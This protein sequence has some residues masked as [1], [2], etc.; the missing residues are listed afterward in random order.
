MAKNILHCFVLVHNSWPPTTFILNS[1]YPDCGI[2]Y[3]FA[4]L[5]TPKH[6]LLK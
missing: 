2:S 6:F 3:C 5:N 1:H 4:N